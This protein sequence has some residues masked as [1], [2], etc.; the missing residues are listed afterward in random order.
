MAPLKNV[1]VHGLSGAANKAAGIRELLGKAGTLRIGRRLHGPDVEFIIGGCDPATGGKYDAEATEVILADTVLN[2]FEKVHVLP[3]Q[4]TFKYNYDYM[5]NEHLKPY[6]DKSQV[7]EFSEGFDFAQDGVRFGVISVL[8]DK[9]YGVVGQAT[10]VYYEGPPIER[11][12]LTRLHVLPFEEGL[13]DK[14][15]ISKLK[16]DDVALKRDYVLPYFEQRSAPVA[17]GEALEI[18]GLRFKVL[19]CTPSKGGGFCKD[20]ELVCQ[21]VALKESFARPGSASAKA[22]A[23]P[24]AKA[25]AKAA[26]ASAGGEQQGTQDG[27]CHIM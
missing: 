12:V 7:G 11:E 20:T 22:K 23:G 18:E 13:P 27:G 14:Y 15:K 4:D 25:K 16:L 26:A 2:V 21:G 8:P 6:F 24:K 10:I 19:T 1:R 9:G 5:Y 17:P 3:Y